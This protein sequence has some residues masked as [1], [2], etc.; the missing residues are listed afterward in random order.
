MFIIKTLI[1]LIALLPADSRW[2]KIETDQHIS[3]LFPN[4][5][6]MFKRSTNGIP[7]TVYQTKDLVCTFGVVCSDFSSKLPQT[8]T[9]EEAL[10]IYDELKKG[11][12]EI[13]GYKL[14]KEINVPFET[15]LIK[16]IEYTVTKDKYEMTYFKR[17]V[18]RDNFV[19][20]ITI[21]GKNRYMNDI[22]AEKEIFFNSIKFN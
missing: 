17:F 12:V 14:K 2:Q 19:Y 15:M 5:S 3:F 16:E 9:S 13:E 22:L 18:F 1:L 11:S 21:G 8:M 20:Q 10:L 4:S 7:S 6:Q